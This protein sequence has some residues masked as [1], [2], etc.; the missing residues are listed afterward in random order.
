MLSLEEDV[1]LRSLE[2]GHGIHLKVRLRASIVRLNA[3]GMTVPR[4]AQHFGRNQRSIHNDL[5]R[6]ETR[7]IAGLTDKRCAGP[8]RRVTEEMDAYLHERLAEPRLWN[9]ALLAEALVERFGIRVSRDAMR[10][11][12]LALGYSW[13][14]GR[15]APGQEP[16]PAVLHEHQASLA[17]LKKGHWTAN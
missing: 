1:A 3:S 11:R 17:T 14:R 15:Y 2:L 8:A 10:V 12:L 7:G 16:D 6:Y 4:L 13:K 5:D 9:S